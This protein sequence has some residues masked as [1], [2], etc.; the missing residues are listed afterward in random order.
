M[1]AQSVKVQPPTKC[2]LEARDQILIRRLSLVR[3]IAI[4]VHQDLPAYIDLDDVIHA[5]VIGLLDA[6]EKYD[7]SKNV[8][9]PTYAKHRI[10][11]AIL[12]SLR[13]FDWASRDMRRRQ[14]QAETIS[15]NLSTELGR[16]PSETEV[17]QEMRLTTETLAPNRNR[18]TY[19]RSSLHLATRRPGPRSGDGLR[20]GIRAARP[21]LR[22]APIT[23]YV[24]GHRPRIAAALSENPPRAVEYEAL[25][26]GSN[27]KIE[28][29]RGDSGWSF[30]A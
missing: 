23:Q 14:K 13:E 3:V 7:R 19:L 15:R 5:G 6:I 4:R 16:A 11:G 9:F 30:L 10:R 26:A 27:V 22:T 28:K 2:S 18:T 25:A 12:D 20:R 29:S 21:H 24:C 17:D 1:T 8:E